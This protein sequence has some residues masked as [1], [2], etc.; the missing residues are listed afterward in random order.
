MA[1]ASTAAGAGWPGVTADF[2]QPGGPPAHVTFR[3]TG[4]L[5]REQM[6][7]WAWSPAQFSKPARDRPGGMFTFESLM[8]A[9]AAR[10]H[11]AQRVRWRIMPAVGIGDPGRWREGPAGA[12]WSAWSAP[13]AGRVVIPGPP[14]CW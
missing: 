4:P 8:K 9:G 6:T 12:I 10:R 7:G 5:P 3:G 13:W 11:T 1:R 14:A 2:D